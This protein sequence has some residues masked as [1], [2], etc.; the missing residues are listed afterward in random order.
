MAEQVIDTSAV[1]AALEGDADTL[2]LRD[3][4]LTLAGAM[5]GS[6][7]QL[8]V[9]LA[10]MQALIPGEDGIAGVIR[11]IETAL[12]LRDESASS[13]SYCT[14]VGM[15]RYGYAELAQRSVN[16]DEAMA[17]PDSLRRYTTGADVSDMPDSEQQQVIRA[18]WSIAQALGEATREID[19]YLSAIT[20]TPL[21]SPPPHIRD[22]C[23]RIARYRLA[24]YEHGSTDESRVY[25]DY[26]QDI[27][28]LSN[29][30]TGKLPLPGIDTSA[31][32]PAAFRGYAVIAPTAIYNGVARG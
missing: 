30:A 12:G 9:Q 8:A 7:N 3:A 11:E 14:P 20:M 32:K 17:N 18:Y 2:Q 10:D 22:M 23:C 29:V 24:R 25:R 19:Q 16:V 13:I 26:K 1:A 15:G 6:Y 5:Q 4:I 21:S 28:Y 27:E 31:A